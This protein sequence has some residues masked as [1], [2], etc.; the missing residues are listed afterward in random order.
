[1]IDLDPYYAQIED[2]C[3]QFDVKR[4]E[5]FG[6]SA[7]ADA[8]SG[9]DIDL[10]VEFNDL[11]SRGISDRYFGLIDA[12]TSVFERPVDLVEVNAVQN[13]YFKESIEKDRR[14][15]YEQ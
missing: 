9:S 15:I 3:K 12:L 11:Y 5:L 2:V 13:P 4:L 7:R 6:S 8:Y 10:L 1:M 14:L